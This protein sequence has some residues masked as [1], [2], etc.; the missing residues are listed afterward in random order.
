[1][2]KL[3]SVVSQGF[4][5]VE[6]L[7]VI[8]LIGILFTI[9][10]ANY[11]QFT[12][13]RIL[14]EAA[15]ELINNFRY[16]Q[17]KAL[18]GEKPAGCTVLNGWQLEFTVDGYEIKAVC[19]N[20]EFSSRQFEFPNSVS[21]VSGADSFLFKVLAQGVVYS[22]SEEI[23]LSGFGKTYKIRVTKSGEISDEGFQ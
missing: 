5:L 17:A 18:T 21:K 2:K 13:K 7:I 23:E 14:Q 12:R 4:T 6:L 22:G 15:L 8:V 11:N 1:M 20:G 16:V 19:S 3:M 10:V 9:G